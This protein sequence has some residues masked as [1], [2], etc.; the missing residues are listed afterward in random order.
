MTPATL[1]HDFSTLRL[2]LCTRLCSRAKVMHKRL[3]CVCDVANAI[4]F[5]LLSTELQ[6]SGWPQETSLSRW[7]IVGTYSRVV[8]FIIG[9]DVGP[10]LRLCIRLFF[11]SRPPS[12]QRPRSLAQLECSMESSFHGCCALQCNMEI[13]PN[14]FPALNTPTRHSR[15]GL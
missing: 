3:A 13:E 12:G 15:L 5:S 4:T 9:H 11:F 7:D 8:Y 10:S 14:N 1:L 2:A 6:A